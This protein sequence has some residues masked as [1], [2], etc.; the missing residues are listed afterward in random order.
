MDI[1]TLAA[2]K[3]TAEFFAQQSQQIYLV[4]GSLRNLLLRENCDDWDVVSTGEAHKLAKQL[5][6]KLSG[7]YVY[8]HEKASR[9]VLKREGHEFRMDVSPLRGQNIEEDLLQRDFTVNALAAPLANVV[10]YLEHLEENAQTQGK[11]GLAPIEGLIDPSN[12]LPDIAARRLCVVNDLVFQ[13]EPLR[14]MRAVRLS[15]SYNLQLDDETKRLI[16]RDAALLP[17]VAAERIHDELYA[18]LDKDG[19]T[20]RLRKLDEVGL[21][22]VIMPEFL[23]A[24]GMPQP[25]PHYWDVFEHS[26]ETVGALETIAHLFNPTPVDTEKQFDTL[27]SEDVP[28]IQNILQEAE[29]QGI[30]AFEALTAPRMKLAALLHDIGKPA[31]FSVDENGGIHFYNHPQAGVP[32]VQQITRRLNTS[33]QDRR[34]AQQVA[35]HHMRPGQLGQ[36]DLVTE[37]AIRRYFVDLGPTGIYVALIS[38]ADHLATLGPQPLSDAWKGHLAVVRLLLT[39]YVRERERILPPGLVSPEELMR[40]LSLEPGPR[41]G[42]LLEYLAEAQADGKIH[43]KEEAIWLAEEWIATS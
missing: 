5:A 43:S 28:E 13:H 10:H 34:L 33:T 1:Q 35:A 24:K 17:T 42:Q 18:L 20:A 36:L 39:R 40:R 4:G 41:V 27:I 21:L 12:G 6:N 32:L 9:V 16:Q 8:M 15:T 22:T 11:E 25:S 23:P 2:L 37:R 30:F 14:M 3:A 38:L 19:A 7:H 31:T 26:L 29:Q